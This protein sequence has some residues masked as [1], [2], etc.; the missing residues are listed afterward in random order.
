MNRSDVMQRSGPEHFRA[1]PSFMAIID[2][3]GGEFDQA[4]AA[5]ADILSQ[6]YLETATWGLDLWEAFLGLR[7][8]PGK[9]DGQRRSLIV[10]KIRGMGTVTVAMIQNV[11]E[12][13]VNGTVDVIDSP[14]TYSFIVKFVDA[15]GIP[16]N[17]S[18]IET[19]IEEIKPAHLAVAYQFTYTLYGEL[20][21]WGKT[22]G[23]LKTMIYG[24]I[25]T[26]RPS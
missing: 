9:P 21:T 1:D 12:S 20:K 6:F 26:Y 4:R 16:P 7:T 11:A 2:S 17:L 25:K 10:S 23:S 18:D 8:I 22:Y 13:Y 15:R 3:E 19:A 24:Q 14:S 5:I